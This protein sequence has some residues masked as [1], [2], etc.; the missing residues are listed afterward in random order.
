[1]DRINAGQASPLASLDVYGPIQDSYKQV[2]ARLVHASPHATYAGILP[3]PEVHRALQRYDLMLFPTYF[4]GEGFP[5][6]I[7]DAFIAGV[8]VL[9]SDWKY[10]SELIEPGRT[11]A[12]CKARSTDDLTDVLRRYVEAP[13]VLMDMRQHCIDQAQKYH[14]DHALK[15]FLLDVSAGR[16][17]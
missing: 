10:N 14:V 15:E 5:G 9:A 8:P 2:F 1:V 17:G 3:P 4:E 16:R 12:L 6:T 7:V 13:Q 11:G